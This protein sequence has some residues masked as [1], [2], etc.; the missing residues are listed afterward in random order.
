MLA[1]LQMAEAVQP[2]ITTARNWFVGSGRSAAVENAVGAAA[3][4]EEEAAAA[5]ELATAS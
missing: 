4:E 3:A 5:D 1:H 2:R